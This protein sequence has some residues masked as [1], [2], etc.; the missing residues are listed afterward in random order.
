MFK[1]RK[2]ETRKSLIT[3]LSRYSFIFFFF[4]FFYSFHSRKISFLCY[5][6]LSRN[7][8]DF[9]QK[10]ILNHN[11]NENP[12]DRGVRRLVLSAKRTTASPRSMNFAKG[13][14]KSEG[15]SRHTPSLEKSS[16]SS[17]CLPFLESRPIS[18]HRWM[19]K[20]R[21]GAR[22]TS[23]APCRRE[24][25]NEG[26]GETRLIKRRPPLPR[27]TDQRHK[28]YTLE[29]VVQIRL[30][31]SCSLLASAIYYSTK[32][33]APLSF[34]S[35][36]SSNRKSRIW[37]LLTRPIGANGAIRIILQWNSI[38]ILPQGLVF[39]FIFDRPMYIKDHYILNYIKLSRSLN[40]P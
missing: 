18:F 40:D 37:T 32:N 19:A 26:E 3:C 8:H 29:I 21:G 13:G 33:T 9:S 14:I 22:Q 4:L 20:E 15:S 17:A 10:S 35:P 25:G 12:I 39:V 11:S 6:D 7:I 30:H 27:Q 23:P 16:T 5:T 38:K 1:K 2:K 31:L 28:S 36:G 24:G 34:L